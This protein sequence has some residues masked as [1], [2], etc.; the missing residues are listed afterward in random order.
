LEKKINIR[1]S[2]YRFEDK[3]KYY[4]GFKN[5]KGLEKIGTKVVELVKL[6]DSKTDYTDADITDRHDLII[7]AFVDFLKNNNLSC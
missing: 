4:K 5:D 1:A 2:D 6:A 7:N 3:K